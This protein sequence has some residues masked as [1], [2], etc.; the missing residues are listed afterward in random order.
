[1]SENILIFRK[2]EKNK[3]KKLKMCPVLDLGQFASFGVHQYFSE[4]PG[5]PTTFTKIDDIGEI[6]VLF[7]I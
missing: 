6:D 7:L 4:A 5:Y 3:P 2:L 1:M